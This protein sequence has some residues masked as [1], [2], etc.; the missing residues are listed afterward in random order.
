MS[1]NEEHEALL[2]TLSS[3]K[4]Y[5]KRIDYAKAHFEF[6]G[7]G[8]SRSVF[9]IDDYRV[10]KI[11]KNKFGEAQNMTE[12]DYS[13]NRNYGD[14]LAK[15][16][17]SDDENYWFTIAEYAGKFAGNYVGMKKAF[18][19]QGIDPE[20]FE[21]M[22]LHLTDLLC[23]KRIPSENYSQ[24]DKLYQ[25]YEENELMMG[26]IDMCTNYSLLPGDFDRHSSWGVVK[27]PD[28]ETK[29]C[30]K[31]YGLNESNYREFIVEKREKARKKHELNRYRGW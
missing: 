20:E 29:V 23:H 7:S 5:N 4:S 16:I 26:I 18:R 24:F 11:A 15:T 13:L 14:I 30:I 9:K 8:S 12:A 1:H 2:Q 3:L 21:T 10:I 25:K 27:Y 22:K 6:L 19:E 31:D 28:G 17:F